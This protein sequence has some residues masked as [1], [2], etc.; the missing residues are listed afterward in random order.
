MS[1]WASWLM[2]LAAPLAGRVLLSLGVG[3][4]TFVGLEMALSAAFSQGKAAAATLSGDVAAIVALSGGFVAMSVIAGG[5][6]AAVSLVILKR[7]ALRG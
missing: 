2:S 3:T 1:S 4:I 6:T 7:F 5:A